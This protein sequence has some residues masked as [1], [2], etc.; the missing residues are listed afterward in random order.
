MCVC[1][2]ACVYI[3]IYTL[4]LVVS[5]TRPEEGGT[6]KGGIVNLRF[7][8]PI[9][10]RVYAASGRQGNDRHMPHC[11]QINISYTSAL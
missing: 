1:M 8:Q 4:S 9:G 11:E 7:S 10:E 6:V 5:V 3:Y 2:Y